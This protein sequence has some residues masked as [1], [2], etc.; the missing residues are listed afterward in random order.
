MARVQTVDTE[1]AENLVIQMEVDTGAQISVLGQS[2]VPMLQLQGIPLLEIEEV[3]V[4]W[5]VGS[6]AFTCSQTMTMSVNLEG[7]DMTSIVRFYVAPEHVV[8]DGLVMG[9]PELDACGWM[10]RLEDVRVLQREMGLL[11]RA[12]PFDGNISFSDMDGAR[13]ETDDLL[14]VDGS[15]PD[16]PR[17]T[18][19]FVDHLP[20]V[21]SVFMP[22]EALLVRRTLQDY[23]EVF[24][25][26]LV[27]GGARV[28]PM[29]V[30]MKPEWEPARLQPMRK[31]APAVQAAIEK[32]LQGQLELGIVEPSDAPSG[33]PVHMVRKPDSVSG[34]RFCIDFTEVNKFVVVEPFPM[35]TIQTVL[36]HAAGARYFGKLD[37]RAGYWQ[38]PLAPEDRHK[39]AFQV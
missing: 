5:V 26:V 8:L 13:V 31:Y 22:E 3:N 32:E 7:T 23:A 39:V 28:E 27:P 4:G 10:P 16:L 17:E 20:E 11:G 15:A 18:K 6:T 34:Y 33:A 29:H 9:W 14:W 25:P 24:D 38:F 37:L 12:D 2:W 19:A 36:D 35:P 1:C 30:Q 21:G